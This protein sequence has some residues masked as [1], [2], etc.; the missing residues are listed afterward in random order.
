MLKK[1]KRVEN[2]KMMMEEQTKK[3]RKR[4]KKSMETLGKWDTGKQEREEENNKRKWPR[5]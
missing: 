3:K 5:N 1:L 4:W 2:K